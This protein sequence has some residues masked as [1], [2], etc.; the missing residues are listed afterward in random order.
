[1]IA[2]FL[3]S[4][5]ASESLAPTEKTRRNRRVNAEKN[6]SS[7]AAKFALYP[8]IQKIKKNRSI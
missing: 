1:V 7:F 8:E 3:F 2:M 5:G 4:V 6:S